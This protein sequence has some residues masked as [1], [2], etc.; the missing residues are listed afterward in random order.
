MLC[1]EIESCCAM[2]RYDA[3]MFGL[4]VVT[5]PNHGKWVLAPNDANVFHLIAIVWA[6]AI[7]ASLDDAFVFA[8]PGR[9]LCDFVLLNF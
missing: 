4:G 1:V 8:L 3:N 7:Q 5:C 9:S 6:L 2:C